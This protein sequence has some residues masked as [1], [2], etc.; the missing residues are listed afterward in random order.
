MGRFITR[1]RR[2]QP[3]RTA[4]MVGLPPRLDAVAVALGPDPGCRAADTRLLCAAAGGAIAG[5]GLPLTAALDA[6]R[7]TT[8]AVTGREPPY[9]ALRALG[10][11]WSE[12]TLGYLREVTCEDPLTGLASLPHLRS[13]LGELYR[14]GGAGVG[15]ARDH[16]AL[17]VLDTPDPPADGAVFGAALRTARL[18]DTVRTVFPCGLTA[19]R[20]GHERI[21]VLVRRDG[22]LD[23]RLTLVRA[24]LAHVTPAVRVW[25]EALP[26]DDATAAALLDQL[27]QPDR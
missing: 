9:S 8:C 1:T 21:V 18:A 5:D 7:T 12:A 25:V 4:A 17:L 2:P 23:R 6:L 10:A 19:G 3:G 15:A 26:Q 13:R 22:R 24:L 16:H 20:V 11:G 14:D 27:S